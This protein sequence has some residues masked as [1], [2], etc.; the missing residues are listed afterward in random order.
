MTLATPDM[1]RLPAPAVGYEDTTAQ[2]M[3]VNCQAFN[4]ATSEDTGNSKGEYC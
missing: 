4:E 2:A 1:A 3:M